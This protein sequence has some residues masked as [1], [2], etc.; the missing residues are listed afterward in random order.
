M[1]QR[2]LLGLISCSIAATL[3]LTTQGLK[4]THS[5]LS[6]RHPQSQKSSQD[7][8][9]GLLRLRSLVNPVLRM[10]Q[11]GLLMPQRLREL[12]AEALRSPHAEQPMARLCTAASLDLTALPLTAEAATSFSVSGR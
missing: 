8:G 4:K 6:C 9:S 2:M 10:N 7:W 11:S 3:L 5:D 12:Q 1:S